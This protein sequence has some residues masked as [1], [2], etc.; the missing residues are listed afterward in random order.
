MID[1]LDQLRSEIK[2]AEHLFYVSLKYTRTV[3]VIRSVIERFM[4]AYDVGIESLLVKVAKR[5]KTLEVPEQ[6]RKKCEVAKEVFADN[7]E[8]VK[9]IDFYLKLR[10]IF[11]AKYEA[12]HEYR[13]NVTMTSML[14]PGEVLEVNIDLLEEY[15]EKTKKFAQLVVEKI[16]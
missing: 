1:Y 10:D 13:R 12:S 8:I 7:E 3:D 5:R 11:Q 15:F 6:P 9:H 14:Q 16:S 4:N 2:R